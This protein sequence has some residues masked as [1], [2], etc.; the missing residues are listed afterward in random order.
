MRVISRWR[1]GATAVIFLGLLTACGGSTSSRPLPGFDATLVPIHTF[2][3]SVP[4][5]L[6]FVAFQDGDGPW[7]P[8]I[9]KDGV[10]QGPVTNGAGRY[11]LAYGYLCTIG[12]F[13]AAQTNHL[14]FTLKE[15]GSLDVDFIC[16]PPPGPD[17][18]LFSLAGRID[19]QGAQ[20]G[21][22]VS[23]GGAQSFDANT[24]SYQAKVFKGTGDLAGWTFSDPVNQVPSRLFLDRSRNAQSDAT[25]DVD[26]NLD[27]FAPGPMQTISYGPV[28]ADEQIRGSVLYFTTGGQYLGLTAGV[29]PHAYASFPPDHALNG[30]GYGYAFLAA[31]TDHSELVSGGR[32]SL[33]GALLVQFPSPVPPIEVSW[34]S[35]AYR[36]P[37]MRWSSV[38]PEPRSQQFSYF[39]NGNQEQ[40]YAYFYF[41]GGWLNQGVHQFQTP[42]FT[43]LTGW[44][45]RWGFRQATPV[46]VNHGQFGQ[47]SSGVGS[48]ANSVFMRSFPLMRLGADSNRVQVL[49]AGGFRIT[50]FAVAASGDSFTASRQLVSTP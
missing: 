35:G 47:F 36:R 39:Q 37:A 3:N 33:P 12:S 40:V 43:G 49:S 15:S 9:G 6:P 26:F 30:D 28:T 31:T 17:P 32:A 5:N 14:F 44:D 1:H 46:N 27:G 2:V 4:G 23:S 11:G 24:R 22:L 20:S 41:S 50:G 42:D 34:P 7:Q 38:S 10:Y 16:D 29:E 48:T 45:N 19:G 21:F 25:K 13:H 8:L 18:V